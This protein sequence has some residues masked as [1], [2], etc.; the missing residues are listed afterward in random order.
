LSYCI[1]QNFRP[2]LRLKYSKTHLHF[3]ISGKQKLI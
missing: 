1:L 2:A 3:S